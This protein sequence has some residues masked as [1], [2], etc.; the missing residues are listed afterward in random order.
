MGTTTLY[1][2]LQNLTLALTLSLG[3]KVSLGRSL[4]ESLK[5]SHGMLHAQGSEA[6]NVFSSTLEECTRVK[7]SYSFFGVK[8]REGVCAE[9]EIL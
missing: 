9:K 8:K 6:K 4:D 1:H 5:K 2:W 3:R 7:W